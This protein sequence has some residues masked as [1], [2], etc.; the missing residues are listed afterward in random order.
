MIEILG[1]VIFGLVM[2]LCVMAL[3]IWLLQD[4]I[5]RHENDYHCMLT[6]KPQKLTFKQTIFRKIAGGNFMLPGFKEERDSM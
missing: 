5:H 1:T 2:A 3:R 6:E 4:V